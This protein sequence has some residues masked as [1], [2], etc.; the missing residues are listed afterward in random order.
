MTGITCFQESGL[1]TA[2]DKSVETREKER[3]RE[4]GFKMIGVNWTGNY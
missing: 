2:G 4:R 3:D 1:R